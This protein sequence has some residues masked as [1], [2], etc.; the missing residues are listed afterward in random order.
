VVWNR[1]SNTFTTDPPALADQLVGLEV[2]LDPTTLMN[3]AWRTSGGLG[4]PLGARQG[5]QTPTMG[6]CCHDQREDQSGD[7]QKRQPL[8]HEYGLGGGHR[9]QA[10]EAIQGW[11]TGRALIPRASWTMLSI[12]RGTPTSWATAA[13]ASMSRMSFLGLAI[14]S[15]KKA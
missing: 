8:R 12:T 5:A 7:G 9:Q 13:T 6:A 15:P 4:G 14:V 3:L 1:V 11:F 2:P 10:G